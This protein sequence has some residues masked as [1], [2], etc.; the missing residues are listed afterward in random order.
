[1]TFPIDWDEWHDEWTEWSQVHS[2]DLRPTT[3]RI[4]GKNFLADEILGIWEINGRVVE[5]SEVTFPNLEERDAATGVLL[6]FEVRHVGITFKKGD[7]TESGG[8]VR[9]FD[10]LEEALGVPHRLSDGRTDILRRR[11]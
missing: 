1:M 8:V 2:A 3:Q 4:V 9:S 5:L 6:R 10:E 11:G 7:E